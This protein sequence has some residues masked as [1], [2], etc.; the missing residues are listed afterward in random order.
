ML[1]ESMATPAVADD[2]GSIDAVLGGRR[3]ELGLY[4]PL[5]TEQVLLQTPPIVELFR[6]IKRVVV[7]RETGCC[8]TGYSGVGKTSALVVI[9]AMLRLQIPNLCIITHAIQNQQFTSIRAFFKH[10]LNTV[11]HPQLGGE[12]Y[13][14]RQRVANRMI[15]DARISG[16]NMVL[17]LIDEAQAMRLQDF[18]FLKD[19][20]NDLKK[21]GIQ[22]I[23]VMMAQAPDFQK[24]V[25]ALKNARRLDLIGR[26]VTRILPY[27]AYSRDD[28]KAVLKLID[29]AE[30]P[31]D[32]GIKWTQFYYPEAFRHGFRLLSQLDPFM[33]AII[34][35][36]PVSEPNDFA[37][38]ARQTFIAIRKF[39]V[40]YSA[41][42][43]PS[44]A[45]PENVWQ[46]A[47]MY[48]KL[49]EAMD[50]MQPDASEQRKTRKKK[51]EY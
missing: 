45:L 15:D 31:E 48:A 22:L 24:V 27:R 8:F 38:P 47:V 6:A 11:R 43:S 16:L 46:D 21:E 42:D 26:F 28:L 44:I 25:D 32:S 37:F 23:T 30:Y 51:V 39:M 13:D 34:A 3:S 33:A 4:H 36:A 50:Q 19:V 10:F 17:L 9:S 40:E 20:F 49:K 29:E 5:L 14:L 12:T 1:V 2:V 7:L 35:N 18:D 41:Y